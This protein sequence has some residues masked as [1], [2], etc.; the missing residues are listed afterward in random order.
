MDD[1]RVTIEGILPQSVR[2]LMPLRSISMQRLSLLLCFLS[3]LF[4]TAVQPCMALELHIMA[5]DHLTI[6]RPYETDGHLYLVEYHVHQDDS[7]TVP[8]VRGGQPHYAATITVF[9]IVH[10]ARHAIASPFPGQWTERGC[11]EDDPAALVS[12]ARQQ[13]TRSHKGQ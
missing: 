6:E 8:A 4:V 12:F 3:S 11:F 2:H 7:Y 10:G 5:Q 9:E 13:A 1:I